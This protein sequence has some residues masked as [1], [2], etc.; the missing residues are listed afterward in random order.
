LFRI[1]TVE[2][3]AIEEGLDKI[4]AE[5]GIQVRQYGPVSACL[6]YER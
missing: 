4:L 6:D 1:E 2:K 3:Q 5:D